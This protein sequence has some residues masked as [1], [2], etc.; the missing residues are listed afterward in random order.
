M[1]LMGCGVGGHRSPDPV[2]PD[3]AAP[4]CA[5]GETYPAGVV[6]PMAVG[7]VI[8]PYAWPRA[9]D[10][11]TDAALGAV[12]LAAAPCNVDP[13]LDWSPA[14]VLLFVSIPAW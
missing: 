3:G 1:F 7:E 14:D 10:R 5:D 12:D 2:P 4:A 11:A 13:N 9:I 8:A 6:E